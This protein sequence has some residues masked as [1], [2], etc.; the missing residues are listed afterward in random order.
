MSRQ[1]GLLT[2]F[3]GE[4][5]HFS[6]AVAQQVPLRSSAH[7]TSGPE[8]GWS[9]GPAPHVSGHQEREE[10]SHAGQEHHWAWGGRAGPHCRHRAAMRGQW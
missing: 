4:R 8:P 1:T 2:V 9:P 7:Y 3:I 10:M 5:P 6:P